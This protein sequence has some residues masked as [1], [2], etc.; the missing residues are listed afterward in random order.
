MCEYHTPSL[1]IAP[2]LRY[3]RAVFVQCSI[4]TIR[5]AA[6][7]LALQISALA[8]ATGSEYSHRVWRI[9]DGLPQNRIRALCQTP[10]GYLWIGTAEGLARFDGM[11]FTI[12][13]HSNAPALHDDG[14][15][16]LRVARDG[17]LWIGT[18]GGGLVRYKDG[19]FH[20]FGRAEGLTNGFVRAIHED[21][22]QTLW[23]GTDRGFFHQTGDR[24]VRLDDTA[25]VPLATVTGIGEDESGRI[26]AASAAGLLTV[27]DGKLHH[28]HA[29]CTSVF[30][31]TLHESSHGFV[32]ALGTR[33]A[34]RVRDG[35][36]VPGPALPTVPM[37]SLVEESDGSLWIGTM[38]EGLIRYRNGETLSFTA[39]SGLPDNTV[40]VVFQDREENLWIGCEDGLARLTKRSG[41]NIGSHEGLQD[42]NVL[43]VYAD[44]QDH[45]W[46]ATTTGQVYGV[47]G[48]PNKETVQ[49]YRLP[50]PAADLRV[51][52]VF[53]DR[54]G[55]FWFGTLAGGLVRQEGRAVT[56]FTKADGL[57]SNTIR[58]IL[59]DRDGSLMDRVG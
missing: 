49:R 48:A 5:T 3:S 6:A 46:I 51:R 23:V 12:F 57:R 10:D 27:A 2:G 35:C 14:I 38:G 42:D 37:R 40:N 19:T 45:L 58:Q 9:E 24:F 47:S 17:A 54:G 7:I 29:D 16:A 30:A 26:W 4:F 33:G 52:T 21:R 8:A 59:Q 55:T 22:T 41:T 18:E 32:W 44:R 43:T 13:D 50:P 1:S 34:A 20:P 28:V 56:V 53:Q 36:T 39:S 31:R 11:R 15:L 25:E